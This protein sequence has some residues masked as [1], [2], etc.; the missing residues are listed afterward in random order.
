M[1]WLLFALSLV[2]LTSSGCKQGV[3]DRCNVNS[4]CDDSQNLICVR[5]PGGTAQSGGVCQ[6]QGGLPSIDMAVS[7][8]EAAADLAQAS[9]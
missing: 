8:G 2:V 1:R 4:D 3:G 7:D 9:D 5:P 6:P